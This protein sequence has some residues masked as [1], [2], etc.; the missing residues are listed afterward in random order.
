MQ[1]A[2]GRLIQGLDLNITPSLTEST[3]LQFA[4]KYINAKQ[5]MWENPIYKVFLNGSVANGKKTFYPKG[6]LM[7]SAGSKEQRKENFKLVYR[8]DINTAVPFGGY[9]VDV[10]ANTGEIINQLPLVYNED[11]QGYGQ[12]NYN[13]LVPIIVNNEF[14]PQSPYAHLDNWNAYG[15]SGQSWWFA[16]TTLGNEGGYN[17]YWYQV[18]DTDPITLTGDSLKLIFY[19]RYST[20]IVDNYQPPPEG[21]NDWDGMNVRISVDSGLTW[22]VLEN[23][24]PD[25]TYTSLFSFGAIYGE[26]EGIPGWSGLKSEWTEVTFDL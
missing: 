21:Y 11:V 4:L 19:H 17:N 9:S 23:P 10:D 26:G 7:L 8:F 6:K 18:L 13:G 22:Q 3:A 16:D 12:S 25:Y 2:H 1:Y 24:V 15:G 14:A 5:Y 20:E